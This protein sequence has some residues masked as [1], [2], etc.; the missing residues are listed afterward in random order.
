MAA[1]V[2]TRVTGGGRIG[3]GGDNER[4]AFVVRM[5]VVRVVVVRVVSEEG[6][7]VR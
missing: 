2:A 1:P 3:G 5:V 4:L 7:L 6:V